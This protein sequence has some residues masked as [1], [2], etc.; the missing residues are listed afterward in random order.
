MPE[1]GAD[2]CTN[3]S[4]PLN[5]IHGCALC[6]V[7][8]HGTCGVFYLDESIKYQNICHCCCKNVVAAADASRSRNADDC[9]VDSSAASNKEHVTSQS[10]SVAAVG[11]SK[12][13][14]RNLVKNVD[15]KSITWGDIVVG[16]VKSQ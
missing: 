12:Q 4:L 16:D 10:V 14:E 3:T 1:C 8:L 5:G 6:K 9:Q 7:E 13:V 15:F 11:T 2:P